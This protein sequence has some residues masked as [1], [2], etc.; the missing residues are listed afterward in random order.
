LGA[1]FAVRG[2]IGKHLV[3]RQKIAI[4]LYLLYVFLSERI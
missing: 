4:W 1:I 2:F 3:A